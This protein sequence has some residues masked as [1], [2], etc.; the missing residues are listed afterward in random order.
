MAVRRAI[1]HRIALRGLRYQQ[2]HNGRVMSVDRCGLDQFELLNQALASQSLATR[3]RKPVGERFVSS[4][5][6]PLP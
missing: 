3:C 5:T 4:Y 6:F 1:P 2:S